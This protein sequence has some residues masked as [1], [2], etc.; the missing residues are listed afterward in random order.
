[1]YIVYLCI[2]FIRPYTDHIHIGEHGPIYVYRNTKVISIYINKI[3]YFSS[4]REIDINTS[5]TMAS[6]EAR[7]PPAMF[8]CKKPWVNG[9]KITTPLVRKHGTSHDRYWTSFGWPVVTSRGRS[10]T[11]DVLL[12]GCPAVPTVPE[13]NH[14]QSCRRFCWVFTALPSAD[15][16]FFPLDDLPF[17]RY[18][19]WVILLVTLRA[20]P[21]ADLDW[22]GCG[23]NVFVRYSYIIHAYVISCT[24]IHLVLPGCTAI[25]AVGPPWWYLSSCDWWIS[26]WTGHWSE[27]WGQLEL[28]IVVTP[29]GSSGIGWNWWFLKIWWVT[30]GELLIIGNNNQQK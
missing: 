14:P 6:I 1:M 18:N 11:G 15:L 5:R 17:L 12:Y 26:W 16:T 25:L 19:I 4:Y 3:I 7:F 20:T 8:G 27:G 24:H 9:L 21:R 29:G 23:L 22:F 2:K 13:T 10:D 30:N 28:L